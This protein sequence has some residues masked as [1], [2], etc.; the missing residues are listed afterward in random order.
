MHLGSGADVR[1]HYLGLTTGISLR[2]TSAF[3]LDTPPEIYAHARLASSIRCSVASDGEE[4]CLREELS[5]VVA[6]EGAL[7]MAVVLRCCLA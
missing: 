2:G 4:L 1:H 7:A 6:G 5:Y 3:P